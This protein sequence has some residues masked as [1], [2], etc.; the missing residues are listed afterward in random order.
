M[1]GKCYDS[2]LTVEEYA[3]LEPLLPA[4]KARGRPRSVDLHEILNTIFYLIIGDTHPAS[5]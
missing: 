3:I 5:G 1:N 2:D 4:P